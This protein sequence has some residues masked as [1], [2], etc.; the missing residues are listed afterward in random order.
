LAIESDEV[1]LGIDSGYESRYVALDHYHYHV[2]VTD[3]EE[4]MAGGARDI[5]C[6]WRCDVRHGGD[7]GGHEMCDRDSGYY[8]GV[9]SE[10]H[11]LCDLSRDFLSDGDTGFPMIHGYSL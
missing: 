2:L 8:D 10:N 3:H 7:Y 11:I 4:V 9:E 1:V 6:P 5:F